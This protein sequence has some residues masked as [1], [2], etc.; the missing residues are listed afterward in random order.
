MIKHWFC[1]VF[2]VFFFKESWVAAA[3][4]NNGDVVIYEILKYHDTQSIR[5]HH[6]CY[7]ALTNDFMPT[8]QSLRLQMQLHRGSHTPTS[9][10][11]IWFDHK[12]GTA[13]DHV[14]EDFH[15]ADRGCRLNAE[16]RRGL[17]IQM[18]QEIR[19]KYLS[20]KDNKCVSRT[21]GARESREMDFC[22]GRLPDGFMTPLLSLTEL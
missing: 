22:L 4:W 20:V 9:V 10:Q 19:R 8:S 11:R 16:F 2:V 3:L 21:Q 13:R 12:R 17:Q 6:A 1:E 5:I 15:E 14:N 18:W 7:W